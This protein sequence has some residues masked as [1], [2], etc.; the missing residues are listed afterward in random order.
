VE[1]SSSNCRQ[2]LFMIRALPLEPKV[3]S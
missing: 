2:K 1:K 3:R